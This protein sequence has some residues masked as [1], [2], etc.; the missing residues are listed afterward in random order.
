MKFPT[1]LMNFYYSFI[2]KSI[3]LSC[4]LSLFPMHDFGHA[5]VI[6]E[7]LVQYVAFSNVDISLHSIKKKKKGVKG[8]PVEAQQVKD[9][10]LSL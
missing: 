5:L 1:M 4:I 10:T 2:L 3:G 6:W 8:V 7:I 9:S